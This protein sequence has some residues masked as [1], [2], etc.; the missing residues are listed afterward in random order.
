VR[1]DET[2]F[3]HHLA[4]KT[5]LATISRRFLASDTRGSSRRRGLKTE[6]FLD[7]LLAMLQPFSNFGL[8]G[9]KPLVTW[10]RN[11]VLLTDTATVRPA[12]SSLGSVESPTSAAGSSTP[13]GEDRVSRS[14]VVLN[15]ERGS[16]LA[17]CTVRFLVTWPSSSCVKET[18][19]TARGEGYTFEGGGRLRG[20]RVVGRRN[21]R[22]TNVDRPPKLSPASNL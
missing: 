22:V 18:N 12:T 21:M 13:V 9:G 2:S 5:A 16:T 14:R 19:S 3:T 7:E 6:E 15:K 1:R 17:L 8:R 4:G 20:R 11:N 10:Q